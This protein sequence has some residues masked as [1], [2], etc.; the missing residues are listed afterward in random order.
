MKGDFFPEI[1]DRM[2]SYQGTP[3]QVE[4]LTRTDYLLRCQAV[5]FARRMQCSDIV[6]AFSASRPL[7][8]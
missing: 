5:I 8:D 2:W 7:M 3:P 4:H 6:W 1:A